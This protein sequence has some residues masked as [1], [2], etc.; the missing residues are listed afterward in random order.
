[1]ETQNK[2]RRTLCENIGVRTRSSTWLHCIWLKNIDFNVE[3]DA[4]LPEAEFH[5]DLVQTQ[6]G[7]QLMI[8]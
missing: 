2:Y 6:L 1:M 8:L 5:L 7:V 4:P 3:I